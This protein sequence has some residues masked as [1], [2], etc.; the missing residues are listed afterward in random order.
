MKIREEYKIII[1]NCIC[2]QQT[3]TYIKEWLGREAQQVTWFGRHVIILEF[4][5]ICLEPKYQCR[6]QGA[7]IHLTHIKLIRIHVSISR[8][9]NKYLLIP[10]IRLCFVRR[11]RCFFHKYSDWKKWDPY[12]CCSWNDTNWYPF[13]WT[14]RDKVLLVGGI[15]S[16]YR[17]SLICHS[18]RLIKRVNH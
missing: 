4:D 6:I 5:L 1:Y 7:Y 12:K 10:L 17:L 11:C 18:S 2:V 16:W 14:E 13:T 15:S 3:V 8:K 9:D